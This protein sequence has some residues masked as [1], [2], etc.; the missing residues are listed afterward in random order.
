M[1]LPPSK[2]QRHASLA[3]RGVAS[4]LLVRLEG[5]SDDEA[6]ALLSGAE[7]HAEGGLL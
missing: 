6:A 7:A 3:V 1:T 5:L 2:I 4:P